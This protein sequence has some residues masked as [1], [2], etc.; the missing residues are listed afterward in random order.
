MEEA[1]TLNGVDHVIGGKAILSGVTVGFVRN[2]VNMVVGP[3]GA[4]KSTLLKIAAGR[5]V[6][7]RGEIRFGQD[8][9]WQIGAQALAR[10]RAFLAQHVEVGFAITAEAVVMMGRYP[11]FRRAPGAT[12]QLIVDAALDLVG[13]ATLRNRIFPTLSGGEQQRIHL[14]RVFAQIWREGDEPDQTVLFLDEPLAA[15]DIQHQLQLVEILRR[16]AARNCTI[17]MT[18][19]DLNIAL[20]QADRLIFLRQGRLEAVV[21]EPRS[22][23]PALIRRVF[24]VGASILTDTR[25]RRTLSFHL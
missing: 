9:I 16:L 3:N 13:V 8:D 23:E 25:G 6:P 14:A 24:G 4:G 1:V 11:Y 2:R 21:D 12:D 19:H 17:V 15:L 18:V 5:T 7:A 22:T 10:R 20:E